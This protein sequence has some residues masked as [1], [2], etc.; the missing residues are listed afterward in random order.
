[1]VK[2]CKKG[3]LLDFLKILSLGTRPVH[4]DCW[5]T[6]AGPAGLEG[7]PLCAAG[8][9]ARTRAPRAAASQL[10]RE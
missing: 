4:P 10:Y 9:A 2:N 3:V 5:N 1:M 8:T 7:Y 6:A